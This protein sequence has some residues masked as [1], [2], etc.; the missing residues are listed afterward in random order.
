MFCNLIYKI[1][2]AKT[3][4]VAEILQSMLF[5]FEVNID[6]QH[7]MF[8]QT[9]DYLRSRRMAKELH[10]QIEMA[11]NSICTLLP[12]RKQQ[13]H[14]PAFSCISITAVRNVHALSTDNV[15]IT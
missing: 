5:Y 6:S 9:A 15:E 3:I 11:R 8:F 13:Y 4:V 12:T 1:K 7:R 2:R 14:S 10:L